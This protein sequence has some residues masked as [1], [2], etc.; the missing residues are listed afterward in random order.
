M[1]KS[2][3]VEGETTVKVVGRLPK[4]MTHNWMRRRA[5]IESETFTLKIFLFKNK[6]KMH[7]KPEYTRC[8]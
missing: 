5:P 2:H 7:G 3:G 1:I 4:R 6:A 8:K